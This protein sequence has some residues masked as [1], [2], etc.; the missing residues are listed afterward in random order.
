MLSTVPEIQFCSYIKMFSCKNSWCIVCFTFRVGNYHRFVSSAVTIVSYRNYL[1]YV[2]RKS[3]ICISKR[4]LFD[5][6]ASYL[7]L[8]VHF[9][10]KS[11]IPNNLT[12]VMSNSNSAILI[13]EHFSNSHGPEYCQIEGPFSPIRAWVNMFDYNVRVAV[14]QVVLHGWIGIQWHQLRDVV[15]HT[16]VPWANVLARHI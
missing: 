13:V 12:M 7:D 14:F 15:S 5:V 10:C 16:L 3:L 9:F 6:C 8:D 2:Q 1:N 4:N 11:F